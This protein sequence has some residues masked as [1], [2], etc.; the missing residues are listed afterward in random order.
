SLWSGVISC[1][2]WPWMF[3]LLR[4]IRRHWNIK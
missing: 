1:I 4:R 3:L 2:L